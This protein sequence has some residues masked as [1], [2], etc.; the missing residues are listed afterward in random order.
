MTR[1]TLGARLLAAALLPCACAAFA[2]SAH[3]PYVRESGALTLQG[4]GPVAPSLAARVAPYADI[5]GARFLA[6]LPDGSLLVSTRFADTA[7]I[8]RVAA[9]LGMRE[10]LTYFHNPVTAAAAPLA[11]G[12][13]FAFLKAHDG[14]GKDQVF[15]Y[16]LAD[17]SAVAVTGASARHGGLV[18][19]KDGRRLAFYGNERGGASDDIYVVAPGPGSKPRLVVPGQKGEWLPLDWSSDDSTLLVEQRLSSADCGL[20]LASVATGALTP[21]VTKDE[22]SPDAGCVRAARFAP[23][24]VGLYVI[25]DAASDFAELRYIDLATHES[26]ALTASIPWDV[27]AFD[28]S[29]DGRYV[30]YVVNADG[31]SRLTVLDTRYKLELSP[32]GIPQGVI[33]NIG[34]DRTGRRLALT[35]ESPQS[36]PDVYVFDIA[37]DKVVRWTRSEPG[38]LSASTFVPA[39]LVHFATWDRDGLH[40]RMLSAYVYRPR[41]PGPYPVLIDIHDGPHGEARPAFDPFIQLAVN[42]LG[43]AV[44]APNVRGSSGYGHEFRELDDGRRRGDAVRD[45]GALLVWIGVQPAFDAKR[46]CVM[47]KGYGGW[48]ALASLADYNDHLDGGIDFAG[49]TDFVPYLERAPGYLAPALSAEFGDVGNV[50]VRAFLDSLS[51]LVNERWI[52]RPLLVVQGLEDSRIPAAQSEELIAALRSRGDDVWYLAA[53]D[54]GHDFRRRGDLAAYYRVAAAFLRSLAP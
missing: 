45:I 48:I 4:V 43:Y 35:A 14:D 54:E 19:S 49:I 30:A 27:D 1:S 23:G 34:F 17:R 39:E 7:E 13:D 18:W 6:W 12:T 9:P 20:Y 51:P 22:K 15:Y 5:R 38:P 47:G 46:V 32:P 25:S 24:G 11:G 42:V 53:A 41:G 26:R 44:V 2:Q 36:P 40:R 10:Q 29:P 3:A 31:M 8:H 37:L 28:V 33:S 21:V 52:Q 50:D 16:R